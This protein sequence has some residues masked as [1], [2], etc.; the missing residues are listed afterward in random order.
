MSKTLIIGAVLLLLL[1]F[2][3]AAEV[4]RGPGAITTKQV[5]RQFEV[6]QNY[7]F[8]FLL[9]IFFVF[10]LY[11]QNTIKKNAFYG[12]SI[13]ALIIMFAVGSSNSEGSAPSTNW[14]ANYALA[15]DGMDSEYL[16]ETDYYDYSARNIQ[17]ITNDIAQ[18]ASSA[19]DATQ[20]V[21]DYIYFNMDYNGVESDKTCFGSKASDVLASKSFQCDTGSR[22]FVTMMR[23]MG[24][25]ARPVGGCVYTDPICDAKYSVFSSVGSPMRKPKFIP[26]QDKVTRREGFFGEQYIGR[27]ASGLHAWAEVY[28]PDS[29]WTN[30]EVTTGQFISEGCYNYLVELYPTNNDQYHLCVS[31]DMDFIQECWSMG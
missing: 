2:S 27:G 15:T 5:P 18:E 4:S 10:Y 7:F 12:I 14:Q 16:E 28:L 3:V 26:L 19:E 9:G 24:V 13:A 25:Y 30:V 29:G 11:K 31:E 8:I 23:G 6:P 21:L 20:M 22:L 17:V 1:A